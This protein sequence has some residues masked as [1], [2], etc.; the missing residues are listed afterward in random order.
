M[1]ARAPRAWGRLRL[2]CTAPLRLVDACSDPLLPTSARA[3]SLDGGK[4]RAPF[5]PSPSP[6]PNPTHKLQRQRSRRTWGRFSSPRRQRGRS[7]LRSRRA[8][9]RPRR[10]WRRGARRPRR[11]RLGGASGSGVG[12]VARDGAGKSVSHAGCPSC[13]TS[14]LSTAEGEPCHWYVMNS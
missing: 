4:A 1:G 12:P 13:L 14:S 5:Y 6:P 9:R 10:R 7:L 2:C 11:R 3:Q 8:S